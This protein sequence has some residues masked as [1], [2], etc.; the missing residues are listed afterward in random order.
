M[1]TEKLEIYRAIAEM[2]YVIAKVD[3]GLS[4]EERRAFYDV[5]TEE[6]EYDAWAAQSRFELLDEI[7]DP[8]IDKAYNEA[9]HD[10]RKYKKYLTPEMKEKTIRVVQRVADACHGLNEKEAFIID[11]IRKD[12]EKI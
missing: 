11:R 8:T 12:F 9:M 2:A 6:L 5:I 4:S 7:V 3:R 10:F 1:Q